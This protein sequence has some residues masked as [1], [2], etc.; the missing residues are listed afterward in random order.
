MGFVSLQLL[1]WILV[2][3]AA[4]VVGLDI[5][6]GGEGGMYGEM[7]EEELFGLFEVMGSLLEDSTWAQMHPLP[8][9]ETP[10]PGVEC[11]L[12]L[13]QTSN[14][15][16]VTK[17]HIGPDVLTPPCKASAKISPSLLKLP[18]LK[19]LSLIS[20]FTTKKSPLFL[21][22]SLFRTS[23]FPLLEHISLSSNPGLTGEIPS[24]ISNLR[25][26]KI[27]S[28]SQN[29]LTGQIPKQIGEVINL[30][31]LDLSRNNLTGPIPGEIGKL[32]NIAILD[33]GCNHLQGNVPGSIGGLEFLQKIDLG[34]NGLQGDVPRQLGKLKRLVL[35][36]LGHNSLTGQIPDDFAGLQQLQYLIMDGNPLNA[37]FPSF[38][39]W[40]LFKIS[41][42]SFSGCGLTGPILTK[43]SNLTELTGLSLDNN[44]LDGTVP[45]ELGMLPRLDMLN[46]SRNQ[47]TGELLFPR[48]FISRI[49]ERLDIRENNGLCT[50]YGRDG[51]TSNN[52]R[53][54]L[55]GNPVCSSA[56]FPATANRSPDENIM[57]PKKVYYDKGGDDDDDDDESSDGN[58]LDT[59]TMLVLFLGLMLFMCLLFVS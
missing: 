9:T 2:F 33:L 30:Q 32:K 7:E 42:L 14:T 56:V 50:S 36:D 13:E 26:L 51:E 23:S 43:F 54:R 40:S 18:Y 16:H 5:G 59:K 48:D 46:L 45:G 57:K 55:S 20:C 4:V 52:T 58:D 53:W 10:W 37:S 3:L 12:L 35:L 39:G 11:E 29:N 44:R 34:F 25:N 6:G 22:E 15:F 27:L 41:V 38:I 17:I 49:G 21:P 24:T 1:V 8:C 31:Q 28:L 47:L 19:T